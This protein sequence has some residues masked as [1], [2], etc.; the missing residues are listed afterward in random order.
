MNKKGQ[1]AGGA[2]G[3]VAIIAALIAIYILLLPSAERDKLLNESDTGAAGKGGL[4]EQ[5]ILVFEHQTLR[6]SPSSNISNLISS[7]SFICPDFKAHKKNI[8]A[9]TKVTKQNQINIP[10][11]G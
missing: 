9:A 5:R 7:I 3:L 6:T 4:E 1:S 11:P 2:A 10:I 8:K